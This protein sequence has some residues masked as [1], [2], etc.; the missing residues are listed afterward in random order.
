MKIIKATNVDEYI[1][2]FPKETQTILKQVRQT[3]TKA[4]PAADESVSYAMPA[5][6]LNGKSL[7]YFAGYENH[8]GL[9]ATPSG[10]KAFE[11]ELAKYKQ[12]KGSVQ[13]PLNEPMPL[14]LITKIVK[15]RAEGNTEKQK[16]I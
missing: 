9:Y 11:K 7:I 3:I 14:D 13:F 2:A 16:K 4:A 8:I 10:H 1:K 5:Y 15:F 6:K 12:G